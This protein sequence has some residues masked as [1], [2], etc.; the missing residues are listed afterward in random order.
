[1]MMFSGI[2]SSGKVVYFTAMFPYLVLTIFFF[3]GITLK[4]ATEGLIHMFTPKME[5]LMKPTVWLDAANQVFYSFGLAFGSIISFGSY[6][7]PQK[8]CVKD[9]IILS[10]CNAFTA[11]YACA[12]IF[13][14]LGFKAVHL[15]EK[16]MEQ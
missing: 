11:I 5:M 15:F 4:G 12:V 9:V 14:I 3:R 6:N 10:I 1:M 7:N 8:N 16:C 2:A 13:S